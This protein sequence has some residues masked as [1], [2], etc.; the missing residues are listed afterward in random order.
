[1]NVLGRVTLCSFRL[2]QGFVGQV[3]GEG[4]L[5]RVPPA[6]N[7]VEVP[8]LQPWGSTL[9]FPTARPGVSASLVEGPIPSQGDPG[10]FITR[11]LEYTKESDKKIVT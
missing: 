4:Q 3:S 2:R 6:A 1:M 5:R 11:R 9:F 10:F 8:R 7:F